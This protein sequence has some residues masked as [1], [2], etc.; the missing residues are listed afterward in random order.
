MGRW[1][2]VALMLAPWAWTAHA[3]PA[4]L[5]PMGTDLGRLIAPAELSDF[6]VVVDISGDRPERPFV[7]A[8]FQ[9]NQPMM[10][11]AD[12][13]WWPW[14]GDE[15]SLQQVGVA[16]A[17]TALAFA[18]AARALPIRFFP[19]TISIGYWSAGVM[20][21]GHFTVSEP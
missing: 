20:T 3:E 7:I 4:R 21:F 8:R 6:N 11:G 5:T 2:G 15:A 19:V 18:V 12:G 13:T 16:S 14:D 1:V 9:N 10:Q 17:G